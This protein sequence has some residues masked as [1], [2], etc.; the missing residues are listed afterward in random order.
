M[1]SS[2][3]LA[4]RRI[5]VTAPGRLAPRLADLGAEVIDVPVIAIEAIA[6][7]GDAFDVA[8][9]DW[10]AFTSA[11][12]VEHF[13][14]DARLREQRGSGQKVAAVGPA[15]ADALRALGIAVDLVPDEAVA[16]ALVDAFPASSG[17]ILLPQA[18]AARPALAEGLRAK[19]W[20]VDVTPVYETVAVAV[21]DAQREATATADTV[22]FTS[23]S[24]V[25]NYLD[26]GG[27][28][29]STVV[30]IGPVTAATAR[31][32]GLSVTAV[33]EPHTIDGLIDAVCAH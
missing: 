27:A 23:S 31:Q 6:F 33:A 7:D 10:L 30:C 19:G 32:R 13:C 15:T 25:T 21:T 3:P 14:R 24:T 4:G 28:V 20:T 17:R 16:E 1:V 11:N 29:P 22:T 2:Q 12:G 18:R 5:V 9:Y 26:G 8:S